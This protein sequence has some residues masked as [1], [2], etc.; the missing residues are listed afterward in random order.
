MQKLLKIKEIKTKI[1]QYHLLHQHKEM[2]TG[3]YHITQLE[4]FNAI[5]IPTIPPTQE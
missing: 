4:P 5:V 1:I 2:Y 3:L